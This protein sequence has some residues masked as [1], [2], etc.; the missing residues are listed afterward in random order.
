M[1]VADNPSDGTGLEQAAEA[2][3]AILTGKADKQ[4][5]QTDADAEDAE[6]DETEA[7]QADEDTATPEDE[8]EADEA[9]V[10]DTEESE[11]ADDETEKAPKLL[12]PKTTKATVKV[13]IDGKDAVVS[14]DELANGYSR[15]AVFTQRT[16]ALAEERKNFDAERA[17]IKS[18]REQYAQLLTALEAQLTNVMPQEPDWNAL[19]QEDPL[20]FT[21]QKHLWDEKT[22]KV[23]A[24]RIEKQR[25]TAQQAQDQERHL[26][27]VRKIEYEKLVELRPEWRDAAKWRKDR[28]AIVEFGRKVGFSDTDLTHA[29]HDH[30]LIMLLDKAARYDALVSNKPRPQAK[31]PNAPASI[32]PASKAAAIKPVNEITRMK[33][34]LA[35]TGRVE[36]AANLFDKL[37]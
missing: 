31:A 16:Q 29:G 10:E 25:L 21:R 33:Q 19:W 36:D 35:K 5:D 17:A 4:E 28:D 6:V 30:R 2:I 3:E 24:A 15:T 23:Q 20:E 9:E 14:L 1:T 12:D 11:D 32:K 8:T 7:Q 37:L 13:K 18:E 26:A 34:R 22:A 27:S